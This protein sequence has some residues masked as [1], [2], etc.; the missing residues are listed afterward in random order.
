MVIRGEWPCEELE[1]N[2]DWLVIG[3]VDS[4]CWNHSWRQG[5]C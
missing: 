3:E 5:F 2:V 1:T 4:R